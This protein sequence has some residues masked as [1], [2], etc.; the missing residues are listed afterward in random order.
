[1]KKGAENVENRKKG[2]RIDI[3][4]KKD[5]EGKL[6]KNRHEM[7]KRIEIIEEKDTKGK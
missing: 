7:G 5:T 1:L 4:E 6:R 2:K 3:I